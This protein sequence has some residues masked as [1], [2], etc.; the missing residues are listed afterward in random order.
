MIKPILLEIQWYQ[1]L[2]LV[3]SGGIAGILLGILAWIRFRKKDQADIVV[4]EGEAQVKEATAMKIMAD[5]DSVTKQTQINVA[6]AALKI[7]ET[8][9]TQLEVKGKELDETQEDLNTVRKELFEMQKK[10][11]EVTQRCEKLQ[12]DL[13]RERDKNRELLTEVEQLKVQLEMI[14]RTQ[15]GRPN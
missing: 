3:G 15:G 13:D 8:L 4:T 9:R 12:S 7:A 5:A 14:R 6:D 1:V 10:S 11:I 2:T